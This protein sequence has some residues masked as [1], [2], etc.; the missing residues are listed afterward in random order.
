MK[1]IE[2]FQAIINIIWSLFM[3]W[4][5]PG[6]N[7]PPGAFFLAILGIWFAVKLA[8]RTGQLPGSGGGGDND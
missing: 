7:V 6:T 5:I 4:N 8:L 2:A 3:G 1:F